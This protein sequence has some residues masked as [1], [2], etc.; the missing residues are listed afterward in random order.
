MRTFILLAALLT[1]W[2]PALAAAQDDESIGEERTEEQLITEDRVL[3]G[4]LLEASGHDRVIV[5]FRTELRLLDHGLRGHQ[6]PGDTTAAGIALIVPG[7]LGVVGGVVLLL[8]GALRSGVGAAVCGVSTAL[9]SSCRPSD[10]GPFYLAGGVALSLGVVVLVV[11]LVLALA[12]RSQRAAFERRDELRQQLRTWMS[13]S[14]SPTGD[15]AAFVAA[16]SF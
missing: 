14:V 10:N 13:A 4:R 16:T 9:G 7:G 12:G 8:I 1:P 3:S 5:E 11:G 6:R 2:L 15:G